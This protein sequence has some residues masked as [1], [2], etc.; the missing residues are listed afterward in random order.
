MPIDTIEVSLV[1]NQAIA[2]GFA[3]TGTSRLALEAREID[4]LIAAL[5]RLRDSMFPSVPENAPTDPLPGVGS[6][7]WEVQK[8]DPPGN[9]LLRLRHPG[10]GW[11]A[12]L[13]TEA[14]ATKL[15]NDL[16]FALP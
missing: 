6:P 9:R 7:L 2:V 14:E 13:L 1:H 15:S 3:D 16:L 10:L 4:Q 5:A 12:F 11:L 8:Y